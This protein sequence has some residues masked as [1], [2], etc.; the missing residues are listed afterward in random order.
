MTDATRPRP[1]RVAARKRN[2]PVD[3][4]ETVAGGGRPADVQASA[5][6]Q[7]RHRHSLEIAED[8]VEAIAELTDTVGEARAVD[9]ARLFGVS[10]VTVVRTVAR[11]Q[12]DGYVQTRPYRALFLTD[13]GT[14]LA[15][16]ARAR[17][18]LV[19][20]FLRSLGIRESVVQGDAEGI[21]HH[22]SD[23]TLA[24]FRRHLA[25]GRREGP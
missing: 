5:M 8:Y 18:A 2:P 11:L 20:E 7:T 3:P 10:H 22:V 15:R 1:E 6:R 19:V 14:R 21:E 23:E 25:A 4:R 9:L 17:H 16:A 12:R 13:K 24:A